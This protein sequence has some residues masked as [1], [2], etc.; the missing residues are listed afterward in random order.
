[1][2]ATLTASCGMVEGTVHRVTYKS[3]INGYTILQ[4]NTVQV[5]GKPP[6]TVISRTTMARR[7]MPYTVAL[8]VDA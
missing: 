1:M 4:I 7:G 3:S 6:A 2:E 8:Y 5:S